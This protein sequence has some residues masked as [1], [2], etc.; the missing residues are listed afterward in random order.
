MFGE[1]V[2]VG[3]KDNRYIVLIT[4]TNKKEYLIAFFFFL[5]T[6][7]ITYTVYI[8]NLDSLE[9]PNYIGVLPPTN[10]FLKSESIKIAFKKL[11][12]AKIIFKSI[13]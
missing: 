4:R 8:M 3:K 9:I 1:C 7:G 13:I 11:T 10:P 5:L 12:K 6:I 2:Q